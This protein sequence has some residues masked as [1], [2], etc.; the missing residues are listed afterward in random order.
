VLT[1]RGAEDRLLPESAMLPPDPYAPTDHRHVEVSG[2]GH[3]PHEE[4]PDAVSA[5]LLDWL[6]A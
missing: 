2:A 4:S 3:L 6:P 5:A 1:V